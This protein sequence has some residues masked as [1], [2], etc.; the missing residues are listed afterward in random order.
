MY[1]E[2]YQ[3]SNNASNNNTNEVK[4]CESCKIFLKRRLDVCALS[5]IKLKGNCENMFIEVVGSGGREDEGRVAIL[6]SEWLLGCV[7]K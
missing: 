2:N 1:S 4:N 5:K 6:L 3:A 7:V